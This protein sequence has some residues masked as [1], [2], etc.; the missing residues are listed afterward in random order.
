MLNYFYRLL[1]NEK[2]F[3]LIEVLVVVAI[4]GILAA[5]AAPRII[6]R[7]QEANISNDKAM[8][9]TL[10]SAVEQW[11]T[12][13]E[14][15]KF[16]APNDTMTWNALQPYLD[17]TTWKAIG[18]DTTITETAVV[19]AGDTVAGKHKGVKAVLY[20]QGTKNTIVFEPVE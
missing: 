17:A 14:L 5:L 11:D 8:A 9:K 18:A 15:G 13:F 12:D 20:T 19:A 16:T 4:I 2:G 1:N 3:T 10:T 6:G 7:I